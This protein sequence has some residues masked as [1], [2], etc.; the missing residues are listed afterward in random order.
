VEFALF[1]MAKAEQ[2]GVLGSSVDAILALV[3]L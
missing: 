1:A 3:V 2:I